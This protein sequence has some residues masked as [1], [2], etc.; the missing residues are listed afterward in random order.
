MS[1]LLL[2]LAALVVS[3]PAAADPALP[4]EATACVAELRKARHAFNQRKLGRLAGTIDAQP[5]IDRPARPSTRGLK[6]VPA[7]KRHAWSA[8][9]DIQRY[10]IPEYYYV[11]VLDVRDDGGAWAQLATA[12]TWS[13]REQRSNDQL[14]ADCVLVRGDRVAVVRAIHWHR[15]PPARIAAFLDGFRAAT[16][17][18]LR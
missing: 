11:D 3:V 16:E 13:C 9:V 12:D 4:P 7:F 1:R 17:R 2:A 10:H 5:A 14:D 6:G 18:C 15:R 8:H